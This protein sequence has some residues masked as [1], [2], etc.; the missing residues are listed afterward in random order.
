MYFEP[1]KKFNTNGKLIA[2]LIEESGGVPIDLGTTVDKVKSIR[3]KI[4][5]ALTI[6]DLV[7]TIGITSVGETD[8]VKTVRRSLGRPG[9]VAHGVKLDRGRVAGLAVLKGRPIVALP[10]PIQGAI[11]AFIVFAYPLIFKTSFSEVRK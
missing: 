10:G 7:L 1:G 4:A 9:I 11:N 3:Q 2:K 8:F 6:S 5:H